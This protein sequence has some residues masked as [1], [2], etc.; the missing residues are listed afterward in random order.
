MKYMQCEMDA[1]DRTPEDLEDATR[2]LNNKILYWHVDELKGSSQSGL[3][4]G[5]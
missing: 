3:V 5:T 4:P 2:R 1:M